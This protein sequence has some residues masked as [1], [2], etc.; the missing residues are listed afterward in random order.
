MQQSSIDWGRWNKLAS[1][2]KAD[3]AAALLEKREYLAIPLRIKRSD[4]RAA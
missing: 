1:V 2:E 3:K 4:N